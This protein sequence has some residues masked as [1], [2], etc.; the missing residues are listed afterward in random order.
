MK[1]GIPR[2]VPTDGQRRDNATLRVMLIRCR[3]A[4]PFCAKQPADLVRRFGGA[5]ELDDLA[6]VVVLRD[7][8]NLAD[9]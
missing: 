8:H 1:S 3:D 2:V 7:T 6:S 5:K 4:I 9:T